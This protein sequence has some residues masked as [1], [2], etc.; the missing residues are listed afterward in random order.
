MNLEDKYSLSISE[1]VNKV[2]PDIGKVAIS[3][4][5]N[6]CGSDEYD[7]FRAIGLV[8]VVK[9]RQCGLVCVNPRL[10]ID[11]ISRQY[12]LNPRTVFTQGHWRFMKL[13]G[14]KI[15]RKFL[16]DTKN[17]SLGPR[18]LDVGCGFGFFL[19]SVKE[20]FRN[21]G[22][23]EISEKAADFVE[24]ELGIEVFRGDIYQANFPAKSFDV[25]TMWEVLEHLLDPR[26]RLAEMNRI[27]EDDGILALSTPNLA[28]LGARLF[29]ERWFNFVPT[30]HLYY[31]EANT[32]SEM[33]RVSGFEVIKIVFS[34]IPS[35]HQLKLGH[36]C[37]EHVERN[38][39]N[40]W[41]QL[42]ANKE[43]VE[44]RDWEDL[45][46]EESKLSVK[47]K[48]LALAL[49]N[50]ILNLTRLGDNLRIYARKVSAPKDS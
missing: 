46:A 8:R 43:V 30:Q 14:A 29:K 21:V 26:G 17:L 16:R 36:N 35:W 20:Y 38:E 12:A 32:L 37:F 31:F 47:A 3:V 44:R 4:N 42:L 22:G 6:L 19:Y 1:Y 24:R 11:E 39:R 2:I 10:T 48:R 25:V 23:V 13:A 9:C 27:L 18:T 49:V 7:L 50:P 34:G 28:G 5:C 33:L 41:R 15:A 45:A 40:A